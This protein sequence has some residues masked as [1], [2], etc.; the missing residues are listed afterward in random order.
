MDL[1][2]SWPSHVAS[3][4]SLD[5]PKNYTNRRLKVPQGLSRLSKGLEYAKHISLKAASAP[6]V[7]NRSVA[8]AAFSHEMK[9]RSVTVKST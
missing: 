6:T 9:G 2:D 4:V 5:L 8:V 7:P 3:N 1:V